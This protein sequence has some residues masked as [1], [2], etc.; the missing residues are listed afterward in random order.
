LTWAFV[1][2]VDT[3]QQESNTRGKQA[4]KEACAANP[5]YQHYARCVNYDYTASGDAIVVDRRA[6]PGNNSGDSPPTL[7][8]RPLSTSIRS[9]QIWIGNSL[10]MNDP[11]KA[12]LE[13]IKGIEPGQG[14][15]MQAK[16]FAVFYNS[17]TSVPKTIYV[18]QS[19]PT[20]GSATGY[21]GPD[22][23]P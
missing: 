2:L 6:L 23:E 22:G 7:I 10:W 17:L 5:D 4:S 16:H 20:R 18:P 9:A 3:K 14:S 1:P 11:G 13:D 8:F 15:V 12:I 19:C 21:C